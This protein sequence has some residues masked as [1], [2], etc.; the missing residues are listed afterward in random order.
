M[1][2]LLAFLLA[3]CMLLPLAACG[4]QS[5]APAGDPASSGTVSAALAEEPETGWSFPAGPAPESEYERAF[6]YGFASED[7]F[8]DKTEVITEKEMAGLL[9]RV[10]AASGG[11][12]A[13]WEELTAGASGEK[14]HR[15]YGAMFLLYAAEQMDA[16]SFTNG[17]APYLMGGRTDENWDAFGTDILGGYTLFEQG[18]N[19]WERTC[20]S[21]SSQMG[22]GEELN[23]LNASQYYA[24][25]RLSLI[26]GA[27]LLDLSY[28]S[29]TMELTQPLTCEAGIA[30]AVRLFESLP[31]TAARFPENQQANA[32]AEELL[33]EGRARRDAI[34]AAETA[35]VKSDTFIPGE[36]YTGT[37]YYI[38]N[39]GD[40][41]A[42]G[43][44][45]ETPW[46]TIERLNQANLQ[47]GDA[48]FFQRG[49]VWRAAQV[50][51]RPGVTYSAYGQGEKPGLYGS[52]ENGGGGEKW[53]LWYEGED[54]RKIWVYHRPMLDCGA[55]VLN[56]GEAVAKKIQPFWNGQTYQVLSNLW[57]TDQEEQAA[58]DQAS[59][60]EFDPKIHLSEDL[61]FFAQ[62]SSGLPDALPV[63]LLGWMDTGGR[64]PY[65]LT[66]DG[67]LYLRCDQG[68]PGELFGDIE[69]LS[70]YAPFDGIQEDVVIDNLSLRYTGRNLLSTSPESGGALVQ[71]CDLG[72]A[73]GCTAS[74]ALETV[75]GYAAGVQR[76]GGVG[77]ANSSRNMFRNNY[78]HE[79]YQEGLGLETAI[80][81]SGTAFDLTDVTF[82]GNVFYHCGSPL[83]YFNWDE[84][85]RPDHQFR[86]VSFQGNYV[87]YSTMSGWT[88]NG[89]EI[90]G[91]HTGAF[92]MEGGPNMQDDTV[93]VQDN[94][95]FAAGESLVY[96][97][98]YTEEYLPDFEGN[99]Y[100]Q[101]S[102]SLFLSSM[103]APCYWSGSAQEGVRDLLKDESGEVLA[104]S[105]NRWGEIDW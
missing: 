73:G 104:L 87:F 55:I 98:T 91:A 58:E 19:R 82:K 11:D 16:A 9:S 61:T 97:N 70:P 71:N 15:D 105:R 100:L 79:S 83:L 8:L 47:Y 54:G 5:D 92:S 18:P 13:G 81:F 63:Y 42:D 14:I 75:T 46:A 49:G 12:A 77:G 29:F 89:Q 28:D 43:T 3:G 85:P 35:I 51:T 2:R 56:G 67:P 102:D 96:I 39:D 31:E 69:F 86:N 45:P 38:A 6:W 72:W 30:A 44:S 62:A 88:D 64:E 94:V 66:A 10:I 32:R 57:I 50:E 25:S 23:Y 53:S 68:N 27:P 17:F 103:S 84:E 59:M 24:V 21:I 76:N 99:R 41:S 95:F 101:F 74:Y 48:V 65:C 4:S 90:Q 7:E 80:E 1:K 36:T 26:T 20:A 22:N 40:D 34:L 60:P 33:Q 37:A 78:V 52:V 93:K